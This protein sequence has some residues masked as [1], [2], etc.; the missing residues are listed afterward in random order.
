VGRA[1]AGRRDEVV[2]AS[3]VAPQ[4][5]GSGFRPEQ[6]PSCLRGLVGRAS[7]ST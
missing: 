1:I 6:V 7:T 5:E 4:P 3:K 2:I